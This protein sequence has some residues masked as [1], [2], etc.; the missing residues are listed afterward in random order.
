MRVGS[1]F[2]GIGGLDLGLER[3]GME[4]A[5][6]VESDPFCRKVLQK[7]WPAVPR[8]GDI[9]DVRGNELDPVDLICGGFPCQPVSCAGKRKG[10]ADERWLWPE[11]YRIICHLEPSWVLVENVPGLLSADGGR[12]F[13]GILRDLAECGYDAEWQVLSA[14]AFGAPHLRRRLFLVAYTHGQYI[15][16]LPGGCGR[17]SGEE[18]AKPGDDGEER[19]LADSQDL[20]RERA[21]PPRQRW[22]GP[23]NRSALSHALQHG[24]EEPRVFKQEKHP[25]KEDWW[26]ARSGVRRVSDGVPGRVDRIRALG[27]AVIPQASE[28]IGRCIME[29]RA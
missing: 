10:A 22:T 5:W 19:A 9:H 7:H 23:E 2:S 28:F 27:N 25:A 12:L 14:A 11:F 17:Q 6:Q 13:A 15:R 3:A 4:I 8:F 1:L 24:L 18:E 29:A 20:G 26:E 21:L 16:K